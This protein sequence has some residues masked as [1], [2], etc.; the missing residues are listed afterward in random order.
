MFVPLFIIVGSAAAI[1]LWYRHYY[2][3]YIVLR[4]AI[5]LPGP[6]PEPLYGNARVIKKKGWMQCTKEW[7]EQ[8]GNTYLYFVGIQ[9]VIFT[10]DCQII[11][12]V[13]VNKAGHFID[14]FDLPFLFVDSDTANSKKVETATVA[15]ANGVEWRRLHKILSPLFSPK[16]ITQ[17]GPLI[18]ICCDRMMKRLNERLRNNDTLDFYQ[19]FGDFTMEGIL[20]TAFGRDLDCQSKEGKHLAQ[21]LKMLAITGSSKSSKLS[22]V[23]IEVIFSHARWTVPLFRALTKN[24]PGGKSWRHL[25]DIARVIVEERQKH[26]TKRP[27]VLQGMMNLMDDGTDSDQLALSKSEVC[28]NGRILIAAGYETTRTAIS[29]A[30]YCLATNCKVQEKALDKIDSYFAENPDASICQAAQNIP[31]IEMVILEALRVF[32]ATKDVQRHCVETCAI[33]DKLVV[34]KGV[35]VKVSLHT[36]NFNLEYWSNPDT[37]DPERFAPN[38][39]I[40]NTDGFLT[41]GAG[42]RLCLGKRLGLLEAEMGLVSILRKYKLFSTDNTNIEID[43]S[44]ITLYPIHGVELKLIPR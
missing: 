30:C 32:P 6:N 35:M 29:M 40:S 24:T 7:T 26:K 31:Y 17:M 5:G 15:C 25:N 33:N 12:T 28:A 34:P 3:P 43:S 39:S 36:V 18:E 22:M 14:R 27:D 42:P 2:E 38:N 9:P 16:K 8:Y 21:Y 20:T 41:F 10:Q 44:G 37:F 23:D 19:F 13:F 11:R 1:W 4:R